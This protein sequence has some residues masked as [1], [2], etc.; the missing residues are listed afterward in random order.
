MVAL[1]D[2]VADG[3]G[4][5]LCLIAGHAAR[6]VLA[7]GGGRIDHAG[8]RSMR[9]RYGKPRRYGWPPAGPDQAMVTAGDR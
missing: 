4:D 6:G 2:G 7:G 8:Q 9:A 1:L 3:A 5:D